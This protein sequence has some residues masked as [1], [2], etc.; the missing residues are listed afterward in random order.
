MLVLVQND[1]G[2]RS[3]GYVGIVLCGS[4]VLMHTMGSEIPW[5]M[6]MAAFVPCLLAAVGVF[7]VALVVDVDCL[8][9]NNANG[10]P[11]RNTITNSDPPRAQATLASR[12][13]GLNR[14]PLVHVSS[15][16]TIGNS[17]IGSVSPTNRS[18]VIHFYTNR[19]SS[20]RSLNS[21]NT[22]NT[23]TNTPARFAAGNA[24]PRDRQAQTPPTSQN[25]RPLN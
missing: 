10:N 4:L 19:P 25:F 16:G 1:P 2:S 6:T 20:R 5:A 24:S 17:T 11:N 12:A 8:Q 18:P 13:N 7:L 9:T 15:Q 23:N 14:Q 3:S 22:S 21:T